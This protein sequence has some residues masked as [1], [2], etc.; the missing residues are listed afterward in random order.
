MKLP[1]PLT[2]I[3]PVY[4][5][6]VVILAVAAFLRFYHYAAFS[7][8]NDELS[9]INRLR[10]NSFH[11]LVDKGFYVDG[12][13]GG[14]QVMLWY[15]VK[16]FGVSEASL[17]LPFVIFGILA[18]LF[19]FLAA[20]QFFGVVTGLFSA[21]A[22][23]FL[24]FPL[25]YSQIARPYGSGM[26]FCLLNVWFWYRVIDSRYYENRS[27]AARIA[28][29]TGYAI[30]TALCMYNHYFSFLLAAI[31]GLTG[32]FIVK[33]KML[34]GYLVAGVLACLLFIPHLYIT[35]NHLTYKGVG[36]WLGKPTP[37]WIIEHL[38]F[39]FNRQVWLLIV[40]LVVAAVLA[41][42]DRK[43]L[44]TN[45]Y[46]VISLIFFLLPMVIGYFYSIKVNPV[47]QHPVLIFSFVFLL[48]FLFSF[49]GNQ[50]RPVHSAILTVFLLTGVY[51]TVSYGNYY[52][53]QHFGEFRDVANQ[54]LKAGKI[55]G[56]QNVTNIVSAN[57]PYYIYYYFDKQK[58]SSV[59]AMTDVTSDS[60]ESLG[61]KV[62]SCGTPYLLYA[63]TKPSPPE[64]EDI[65]VAAFPYRTE[66]IDYGGLSELSIFARNKPAYYSEEDNFGLETKMDFE[67]SIPAV[68][69]ERIR[70]DFA[71]E[72][73]HSFIM[74]SLIE[75]GPRNTI[76]LSDFKQERNL[77]ARGEAY[78]YFEK[79]PMDAI[80]V[81]S[82]EVPGKEPLVWKGALIRNFADAGKWYK[83]VQHINL[84]EI[85]DSAVVFKLY[86]WNKGKETFLVDDLKLSV[87]TVK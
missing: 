36:L 25:L 56:K 71:F 9:A 19:A 53:Q 51:S 46:R 6:L 1:K 62:R 47:L 42:I 45:K 49:A 70:K 29:L 76:P 44:V 27:R 86:I 77:K 18:V 26:F 81:V 3:N 52:H 87:M 41:W 37:V 75:Y 54:I 5:W 57:N 32:L 40:T 38:V 22:V 74:D 23:A 30:S 60:L 83:V 35:L 14:I 61:K 33:R 12:H 73:N 34:A 79:K 65:I 4:F 8:S 64:A 66:A 20:K 10:F 85:T 7:F 28:D 72:G 69:K 48:F 68:A 58:D 63:W 50:F 31:I 11:E 82:L 78:V 67:D 59:L 15:W 17:R 39:I 13:P 21:A 2:K 16:L 43:R 55:Y 24:E 80:L 84:P